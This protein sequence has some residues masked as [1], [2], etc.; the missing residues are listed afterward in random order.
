ML[1]AFFNM[2]RYFEH[3]PPTVV[4]WFLLGLAA[5]IAQGQLSSF[6]GESFAKKD[7]QELAMREKAHDAVCQH[8]RYRVPDFV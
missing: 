8:G 2:G 6:K 3:V 7:E 1:F 5:L 4:S